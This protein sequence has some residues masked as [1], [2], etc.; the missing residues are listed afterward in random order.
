MTKFVDKTTSRERRDL[1]LMRDLLKEKERLHDEREKR[2]N[3]IVMRREKEIRDDMKQLAASEARVAALQQ[4]LQ[5]Q[6]MLPSNL[7][8]EF[9][10]RGR[11]YS[12]DYPPRSKTDSWFSSLPYPWV[13]WELGYQ[14]KVSHQHSH[15]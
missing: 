12:M 5:D 13:P 8:G 11:P 7:R 15:Q 2:Q 9:G 3:E 6:S 4:Q 14:R 10:Q 1:D